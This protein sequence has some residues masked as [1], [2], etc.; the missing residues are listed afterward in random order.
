[1]KRDATTPL[2]LWICAAICVHFLFGGGAEEVAVTHDDRVYLHRMAATV[3]D[4]VRQEEQTFDV[5]LLDAKKADTPPEA[6]PP[7]PPPK[8][9]PPEVKKPKPPEVAKAE[10]K[11]PLEPK[12]EEKKTLVI[13]KEEKTKPLPAP[14]PVLDHRIAVKQHAQDKQ[15]DNPNAHFI[16]DQANHVNQETAASLT[17]HDRDDPNPTPG[18]ITRA[19]KARRGTASGRRSPTASSTRG[20]RIARRAKKG[21][22]SRNRGT[23]CCRRRPRP[24]RCKGRRLRRCLPRGGTGAPP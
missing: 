14:P 20:T 19:R 17:S 18:G 4:R 13:A 23:R 24:Q 5:A 21:A 6:P 9:K 11:K 3:R 15:A 8:P 16:A 12:K 7:P 2:I 1:M 10:K 22:S